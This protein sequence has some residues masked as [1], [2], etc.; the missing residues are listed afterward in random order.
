MS[1]NLPAPVREFA[2]A[3][4]NLTLRVLGKRPDGYHELE[5]L[6]TFADTHDVVTLQPGTS[7]SVAVTGPFAQYI[8]DENLLVRALRLLRD[9][10]PS[11]ALGA[12]RLEKN[13]PVAAGIGGGSA[14]A[15]ALLRALRRADPEHADVI[16]W[17]GIAERLGADVPVCFL[18][19]TALMAGKGERIVFGVRLPRVSAVLANPGVPLA[20]AQVFQA[21]AAGP[22]APGDRVQPPQIAD[23]DSL[24]AYMRANG[25]DLEA[26]ASL[27]LPEIGTVKTALAAEPGCWHAAMSGSGPTCFGIFADEQ[28]GKRAAEAIAAAHPGWW[29]KPTVL[30]GRG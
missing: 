12:V 27:L 19:E 24:V 7:G 3:K 25:N 18:E 1:P 10:A 6:V 20:T 11:I 22:L 26:P 15:A 13:L 5:S 8:G 9:A 2:R 28:A 16:D 30:A 21:L 23:G 29:V 14:D 17:M 4:V